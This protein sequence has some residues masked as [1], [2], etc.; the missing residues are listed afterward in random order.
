VPLSTGEQPRNE[1][2]TDSDK[3]ESKLLAHI[4]LNPFVFIVSGNL[5][6]WRRIMYLP[7][8]MEENHVFAYSKVLNS[9]CSFIE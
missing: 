9:S 4:W 1:E 3:K 6:S 8:Q 2:V 5:P 7:T